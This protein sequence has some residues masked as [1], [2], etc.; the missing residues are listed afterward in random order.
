MIAERN[1]ESEL[2]R[3]QTG[4]VR[5][6]ETTMDCCESELGTVAVV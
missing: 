1:R 3:L 2:R 5:E 4:V 6:P